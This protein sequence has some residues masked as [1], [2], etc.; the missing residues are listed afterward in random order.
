[1][2]SNAENVATMNLQ[3]SDVGFDLEIEEL[4]PRVAFDPWSPI[5]GGWGC[6]SGGSC[7]VSC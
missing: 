5:E 7:N 3:A 4:E 1:M 2:S 6:C